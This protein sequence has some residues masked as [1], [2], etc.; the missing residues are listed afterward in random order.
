MAAEEFL[1]T[2]GPLPEPMLL[3]DGGGRILAANA[4]AGELLSLAPAKL[5]GRALRELAAGEDDQL[6]G[7]LDRCSRSRQLLPGALVLR[8]GDGRELQVRADGAVYRPRR[9]DDPALV[10]VRLRNRCAAT[11]R[12]ELLNQRISELHREIAR[13]REVEVEREQVLAREQAARAKAEAADR[14]KDEFLATLSHEL[15]APLQ[16]IASWVYLLKNGHLD[17][18][19]TARALDVIDRNLLLQTQLIDDLLDIS[20]LAAGQ[21]QV[22][23]RRL[24]LAPLIDDA[25]AGLRAAIDDKGIQLDCLL[26][27]GLVVEGD[28][29]RLR[30]V[31]SN[32]VSNALKFTPGGGVIEVRLEA[33]GE[34]AR[35]TVQDTGE[36][37]GSE[38]LPHV[39]ER[40]RQADGSRTRLHGGLGLGLSI[41]RQLVEL[42]GGTLAAASPGAGRGA[43]FTVDLPLLP[44]A[45]DAEQASDPIP[46]DNSAG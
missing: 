14:T 7:F 20:H 23:R 12:F 45:G 40:F 9:G 11:S 38:F 17:A 6:R 28:A 1:A 25:C 44:S 19:A 39:F 29:E 2:A 22:G 10:L 34:S 4:A 18:D 24:E 27:P 13:R 41:A 33:A 35:I 42:H 46:C 16:A 36:G 3:V 37:I 30:Q 31:I 32:L 5:A 21:V 43:T 8:A 15:R 26:T